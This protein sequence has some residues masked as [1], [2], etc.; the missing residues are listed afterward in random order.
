MSYKTRQGAYPFV[1]INVFDSLP[2]ERYVLAVQ[3]I[4]DR[5]QN[6]YPL[7]LDDSNYEGDKYTSCSWGLCYESI[8]QWPDAEDHTFPISFE[9]DGRL[10]P[11]R[12]GEGQKCPMDRRTIEEKKATFNGCF[13]TCRAFNPGKDKLTADEAIQL[14]NEVI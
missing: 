9:Q 4:L 3:R 13:W 7:K 10:S 11:L 2:Y 14:C 6:G 1:Q 8:D 5:I 12:C